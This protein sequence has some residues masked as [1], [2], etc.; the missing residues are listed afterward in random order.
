MATNNAL[1]NS[2][3]PFD[4]DNLNLSGNTISSTDT[5]GNV[6][7][8]PD[9]TG[10]VSVTAAPVVPSTDRSDSIGSAT[11]SWDNVYADGLTFDDGTNILGTYEDTTSFTPTIT[12]GGAA[13]GVTYTQQSGRYSR[14]GNVVFFHIQITLS[15]KGSSTGT[16]ELNGLP[17]SGIAV[18]QQIVTG[19]ANVYTPPTGQTALVGI[20]PI[21][22]SIVQLLSY[23]AGTGGV[24]LTDANFANNTT[25]IVQGS[26]FTS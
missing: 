6:V 10:V 4:V 5:N 14:I 19:Y 24:N 25:C 9:G 21:S 17:Y 23:G 16:A 11:N 13:V 18:I 26:Y 20:I 8:A 2:S 15:N 3:S 22:S 12:F 7:I 1:N